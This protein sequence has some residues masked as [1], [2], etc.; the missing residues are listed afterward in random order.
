VCI[1][2]FP[3]H[4]DY[5]DEDIPG[6]YDYKKVGFI[7]QDRETIMKSILNMYKVY[8]LNK[9]LHNDIRGFMCNYNYKADDF[10]NSLVFG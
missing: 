2:K 9:T 10:W 8:K 6:S 7:K 5:L 4:G 3:A 1:K